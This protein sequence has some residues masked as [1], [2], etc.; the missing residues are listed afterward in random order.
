M[1]GK[2][3][4]LARKRFLNDDAAVLLV[5]NFSKEYIVK[6]D[7]HTHCVLYKVPNGLNLNP[8]RSAKFSFK[9]T[10][11]SEYLSPR[12]LNCQMHLNGT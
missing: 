4:T 12:K 11:K 3:T 8:E 5:P 9:V 2:S 1:I 7:H 6:A 10:K